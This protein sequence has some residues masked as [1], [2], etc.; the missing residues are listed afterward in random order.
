MIGVRPNPTFTLSFASP[1]RQ[2]RSLLSIPSTT[3]RVPA[4]SFRKSPEVAMRR[5]YSRGCLAL[6]IGLAVS[7][8]SFGQN[9]P[10]STKTV[11]Q[12][13]EELDADEFAVRQE[14]KQRLLDL[15]AEAVPELL[16]ATDETRS[17]EFRRHAEDILERLLWPTGQEVAK[18]QLARLPELV[19]DREVSLVIETIDL[20]HEYTDAESER[21]IRR[22]ARFMLDYANE[23][24]DTKFQEPDLSPYYN[25]NLGKPPHVFYAQRIRST[26]LYESVGVSSELTMKSGNILRSIVF[27]DAPTTPSGIRSSVVFVNGDLSM[28]NGESTYPG[29]IRE[30]VVFCNGD[31]DTQSIIDSCVIA[32][33]TIRMSGDILKDEQRTLGSLISPNNSDLFQLVRIV[34]A[35]RFGCSLTLQDEGILVTTIQPDGPFGDAGVCEGD[36]IL[37]VNHRSVQT[38]DGCVRMLSRCSV[39]GGVGIFLSVQRDGAVIHLPISGVP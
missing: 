7:A 30:S 21:Q 38:A 31:I 17:A 23:Q 37:A 5:T 2:G 16:A 36:T 32:T 6:L 27:C 19:E 3:G 14:A 33:G 20:W 28:I 9:M 26:P 12:L 1:K 13:V 4:K 39:S 25:W 8:V 34:T 35:E 18:R 24:P 22:L 29:P 11:A 15:G 10:P